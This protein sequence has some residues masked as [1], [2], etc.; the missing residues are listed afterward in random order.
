[1]FGGLY[2][3]AEQSGWML[4]KYSGQTISTSQFISCMCF[5]AHWAQA[6]TLPG[7]RIV[8][9]DNELS[10]LM[11]LSVSHSASD[12]TKHDS[13][14]ESHTNQH[15]VNVCRMHRTMCVQLIVAMCSM[16]MRSVC[17]SMSFRHVIWWN[18]P[19]SF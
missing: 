5:G 2:N 4:P 6:Y 9:Y 8:F 11:L 19:L 15:P 16:R 18:K 13:F 10:L 12:N 1:M 3:K 14:T 7:T 17:M